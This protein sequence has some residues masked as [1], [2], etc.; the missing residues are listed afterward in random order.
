MLAD[1]SCFPYSVRRVAFRGLQL[2]VLPSI[3]GAG[4]FAGGASSYGFD[5]SGLLASIDSDGASIEIARGPNTIVAG[6][7][8]YRLD[9]LGRTIAVDDLSISYGPDGQIDGARRGSD[10]VRYLYDEEGQRMLRT[11]NGAPAASYLDSGYLTADELVEPVRVG[12]RLVGLLRKG[13]LT[14]LAADVRGTIEADADGAARP[15]SPFGARPIHPDVAAIVD[16]AAKGFDSLLG[17]IR[18]GVRDYDPRIA[19]FLVPDPFFLEHPERCVEHPRQCNLYGYAENRPLDLTDP[20]GTEAQEFGPE[21]NPVRLPSPSLT[22][23]S[24]APE[25]MP[26]DW[27]YSAR[28]NPLG[29]LLPL[30]PAASQEYLKEATDSITRARAL[31]E[32][33]ES[34]ERI[35]ETSELHAFNN[36]FGTCVQAAKMNA[37]LGMVNGYETHVWTIAGTRWDAASGTYVHKA[38]AL[39][40]LSDGTKTSVLTWG[41]TKYETVN[42]VAKSLRYSPYTH[43]RV[44]GEEYLDWGQSLNDDIIDPYAK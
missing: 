39:A 20:D 23:P 41:E 15:V 36:R 8:V 10:E 40:E 7:S 29:N 14:S 37:W 6:G 16:Y 21:D 18:M 25:V 22:V 27:H 28:L 17:A 1:R 35:A 33:R 30:P 9:A 2:A 43:D 34:P 26:P 44:T 4:A 19:Q 31:G 5:S 13:G 11:V 3:L 24:H 12:G 42:D 38:H 32:L